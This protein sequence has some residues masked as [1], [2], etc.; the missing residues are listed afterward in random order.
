MI[1][2]IGLSPSGKAQDFDSCISLV[3]I[4]LALFKNSQ[5]LPDRSRGLAVFLSVLSPGDRGQ[6]PVGW[7]LRREGDLTGAER[8]GLAGTES[9]GV[10]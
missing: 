1:S 10:R 7:F 3:R 8:G 6:R 5:D 4:Q 9:G 2:I